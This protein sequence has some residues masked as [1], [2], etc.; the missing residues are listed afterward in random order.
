MQDARPQSGLEFHTRP[1][2]RP[3]ERIGGHQVVRSLGEA[4]DHQYWLVLCGT[5]AEFRVAVT[6]QGSDSLVLLSASDIAG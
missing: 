3:G 5:P 4:G 6:Q 1:T 2:I